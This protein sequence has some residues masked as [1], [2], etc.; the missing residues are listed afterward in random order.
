MQQFLNAISGAYP[1]IP[2]LVVDGRF[3][4]A[5][6]AAVIA[7]Q[8]QF[9]LVQDGIIGPNTWARIV[10][11]YNQIGGTTPQPPTAPQYPGTPLRLGSRGAA[12]VTLQ[13][14]LNRI[15]ARN[16]AIP[17][18]VADGGFGP[19]TQAAVIAFQRYYGLTP[20]GIV[21]PLTWNRLMQLEV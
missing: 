13:Q 19:M 6:Q 10:Q 1:T 2:K 15:A 17:R 14:N 5:T 18:I 7:F 16:S 8:R 21:G 4:P 9:G 11:I 12:V 20:D 3:G